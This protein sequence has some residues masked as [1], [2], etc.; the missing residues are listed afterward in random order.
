MKLYGFGATR[1]LRVQWVLNELDLEYE[2]VPVKLK[3]GEHFSSDFLRLNPAHKVPVLVDGDAVITESA[4]IVLY[5][6]EKHPE[7]GLLPT[8]LA[9]RGQIYRWLMFAMTELEQPLWR[10]AR[11]TFLYPEDKRLPGDIE[12]AK[13]DFREMVRVLEQHMA[14]RSY[15][16]GDHLTVADCVIAYALDW[17]SLVGLL[18][19]LP[20]LKAYMERLYARPKA[21]LRMAAALQV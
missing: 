16:V 17:A 4:A 21:P 7:K 3:E 18:D 2:F 13:E 12:L 10:M 15:V 8:D 5:L 11:H 20:Y 1:S 19:G 14:G 9:Q 6:A